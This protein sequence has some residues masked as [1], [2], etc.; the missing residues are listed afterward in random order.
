MDEVVDGFDLILKQTIILDHKLFKYDNKKYLEFFSNEY[1]NWNNISKIISTD[2][3]NSKELNDI[4]NFKFSDLER[5]KY[6]SKFFNYDKNQNVPKKIIEQL[7]K[8]CK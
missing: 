2:E 3:L 8:D 6:L 4:L 1:F 5:E 7:E